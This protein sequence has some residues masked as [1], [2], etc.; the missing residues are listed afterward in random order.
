MRKGQD[1]FY[2]ASIHICF[3]LILVQSDT[4]IE[5]GIKLILC[6]RDIRSL[7]YPT[8]FQSR[9]S[10]RPH[11]KGV[12]NVS[13]PSY[14]DT[15]VLFFPSCKPVITRSSN[16]ISKIKTLL[17][18]WYLGIRNLNPLATQIFKRLIMARNFKS[19]LD[20]TCY[21]SSTSLNDT[22]LFS[23]LYWSA[24]KVWPLNG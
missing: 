17:Q 14:R 19:W 5:L 9:I 8:H 12:L 6:V 15:S 16:Y 3:L 23:T 11:M 7:Q 24:R 13:V 18:I 21:T 22:V 2:L 10:Q 20:E 1:L 4:G